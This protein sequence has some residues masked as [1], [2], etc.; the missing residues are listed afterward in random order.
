MKELV[1]KKNT[2]PNMSVM[3]NLCVSNAM[4]CLKGKNACNCNYKKK[5]QTGL[6]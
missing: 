2:T 6:Y 1:T 3:S 5:K 4:N